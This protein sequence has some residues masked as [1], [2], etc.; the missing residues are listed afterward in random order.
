MPD[1]E[2]AVSSRLEHHQISGDWQTINKWVLTFWFRV[3]YFRL[4]KGDYTFVCCNLLHVKEFLDLWKSENSFLSCL[5]EISWLVKEV[6]WTPM[7]SIYL[8][9][10]SWTMTLPLILNV[11]TRFMYMLTKQLFLR[12]SMTFLCSDCWLKYM[13]WK[14]LLMDFGKNTKWKWS[15]ICNY[16]SLSRIFKRSVQTF[17]YIFIFIMP[18]VL[19]PWSSEIV[20]Q[21]VHL[22]P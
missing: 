12:N 14:V 6:P 10:V 18:E 17:L 22:H 9:Q 19:T 11:Q 20:S 8:D 4:W 15:S 21:D 5:T 2:E 13:T 7:V 1:T 3:S 16:G